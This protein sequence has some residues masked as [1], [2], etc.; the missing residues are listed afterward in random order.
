MHIRASAAG[1]AAAAVLLA[2]PAAAQEARHA[3]GAVLYTVDQSF[4]DV[5]FGVENAILGQGLVVDAIS[6]VGDMLERTRADVGS[7]VVLFD[8]ADVFSFCSAALS[9]AVMEADPMNIQFC[10]YDIFVFTRPDAPGETTIGYR[11]Y[12]PGAMDQI[13]GLLDAIVREAI[14]GL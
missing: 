5:V 7:E 3:D 8:N 11:D 12:P 6:H 1:M 2:L 4:E 10:P 13:E 9:R 14:S